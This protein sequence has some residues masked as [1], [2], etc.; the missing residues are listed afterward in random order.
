MIF[1]QEM[2][3][4]IRIY[5][6][7]QIKLILYIILILYTMDTIVLKLSISHYYSHTISQILTADSNHDNK[8]IT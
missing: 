8:F 2:H 1:L 3:V 7:D 5:S 6:N 4:S